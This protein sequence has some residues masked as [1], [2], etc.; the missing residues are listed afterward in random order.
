MKTFVS[1]SGGADSTALALI[2]PDAIPLFVDTGW[3][4]PQLLDH[5]NKVEKYIGKKIR[6]S[7]LSI[8]SQSP[9][10]FDIFVC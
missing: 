5:V 3:E 4:F 1:F 8:K 6:L 7:G 9:L 2:E 10:I